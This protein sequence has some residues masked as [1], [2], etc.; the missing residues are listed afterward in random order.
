MSSAEERVKTGDLQGALADLQSRVRAHPSDAR[1]RVFLFQLLA[2]MGQWERALTQLK[3][4][5]ELDGANTAMVRTYQEAVRCEAVRAAVFRGEG[6]PMVFGKPAEWIALLVQALRLTAEAKYEEARSLR[7][8]ALEQAPAFPGT[9]DGQAFEWLADADS[10]LGPVL[11]AVVNGRYYWIPFGRIRAIKLEPPSDLRDLA[12]TAAQ[13]TLSNGGETV[14][15]IPTRYPGTEGASDTRLVMARA[16]EWQER[17]GDTFLGWGQRLFTTN[18]GDY[19]L[20]DARLIE[21]QSPDE[22]SPAEGDPSS[23]G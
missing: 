6:T 20:L 14:A 1:L 3:V 21:I 8:K 7:D 5:G 9:I 19:G 16:T 17:P 12:W 18:Q 2:V 23:P 4:A 11:E 22:A 10:R 13:L 15:L